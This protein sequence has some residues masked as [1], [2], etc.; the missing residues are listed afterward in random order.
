AL[1]HD[2]LV[3]GDPRG[4]EGRAIPVEPLGGRGVGERCVRDAADPAMTEIDQVLDG[5]ACTGPVVDVDA[6]CVEVRAGTLEDDREAGRDERGEL[7]VV[8]TWARYDEAVG[9]LRAE[10]VGVGPV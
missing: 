7:F 1:D 2:L 8:G 10:E 4:G 9:P 6:R 3:E 5:V